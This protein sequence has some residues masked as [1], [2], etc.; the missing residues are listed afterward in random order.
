MAPSNTQVKATWLT[1][2][3]VE[4]PTRAGELAK[5]VDARIEA[6]VYAR[7][8]VEYLARI[9]RSLVQGTLSINETKLEKL[10]KL[11]QL[12]EI[13][14]KPVEISSHRKFIGPIIVGIKKLLFPI[15][16]VLFK[17][18]LKQQRDFNAAAISLLTELCKDERR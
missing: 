7:S 9:D 10:R 1:V 18:T 2:C 13:D 17:N 11:C 14:L 4:D 8:D 16:R 15:V 3:G 12:W 6:G 5:K